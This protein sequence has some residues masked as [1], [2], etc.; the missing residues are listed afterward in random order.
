MKTQVHRQARLTRMIRPHVRWLTG[1]ALLTALAALSITVVLVVRRDSPLDFYVYYMAGHLAAHGQSAYQIGA[2]AWERLAHSLAIAHYTAP[3]RYPPYTAALS[4]TL[5]PLG[6]RDAMIAWELLSGLALIGGAWLVGSALGGRHGVPLALAALVLFVPVYNVLGDGQIDGL[7]FFFLCLALWGLVRGRDLPLGVGVAMA[8][9]L[10]LTPA[11][12]LVYLL[13]RRRW[14]AALIAAAALVALT[15]LTLPITGPQWFA[16]YGRQV[17]GLTEPQRIALTPQN[18]TALGVAGRLV[19]EPT[20]WSWRVWAD[21]GPVRVLRG[22][23][24]LF[25]V[26]LFVAMAA[27]LWPRRRLQTSH[28]GA[29]ER[30]RATPRSEAAEEQ[31][32]FGMVVAASLVVGPFTFYHQF[33][34]LLPVLLVLAGRFAGA[35][36]WRALALVVLLHVAVNVNELLWIGASWAPVQRVWAWPSRVFV[37][38]GLWR[39]LSLP[40]LAAMSAWALSFVLVT[41]G[42]RQRD[43]DAALLESR[44]K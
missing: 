8:A 23:S 22:V 31:L 41:A 44:S 3:Y 40:F 5:V 24:A 15:L 20:T 2:P 33:V 19:L 27:L 1:A 42:R 28:S 34:W 16:D 13:W 30:P 10:K 43:R 39:T 17:V 38:S 18:Q 25:A 36:Q 4:R 11:L 37:D 32:G 21:V 7:A 14:R 12:L 6:P 35:R 9:A 26:A 29:R